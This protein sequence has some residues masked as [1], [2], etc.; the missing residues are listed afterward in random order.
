MQ[1]WL[2]RLPVVL[3]ARQLRERLQ[4]VQSIATESLGTLQ[5]RGGWYS[6]FEQE[7]AAGGREVQSLTKQ[8]GG[9]FFIVFLCLAHGKTRCTSTGN[10]KI[11]SDGGVREA[12]ERAPSPWFEVSGGGGCS[13][14]LPAIV[15]CCCYRP[16]GPGTLLSGGGRSHGASAGFSAPPRSA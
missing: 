11:C 15:P 6:W 9:F 16:R 10:A 13:V 7:V 3:F 4:S 2:V 5:V 8:N 1:W 14:P 12:E